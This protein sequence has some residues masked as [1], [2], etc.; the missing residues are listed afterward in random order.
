MSVR[1]RLT[2]KSTIDRVD[3]AWLTRLQTP[4][5]CPAT[6]GPK[7]LWPWC[8]RRLITRFQ[9]D[10]SRHD[11]WTKTKVDMLRYSSLLGFAPENADTCNFVRC[12]S[13]AVDQVSSS[14]S[15]RDRRR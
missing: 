15:S 11:P 10:P 14:G 3:W 8:C 4:F 9:T 6:V 12:L 1:S 13:W 2:M 7:A 5:P